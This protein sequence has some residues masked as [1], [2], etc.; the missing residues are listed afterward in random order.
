MTFL[1]YKELK[2][3]KYN[4]VTSCKFFDLDFPVELLKVKDWY[5]D[6]LTP[7][8][9]SIVDTQNMGSN[10]EERESIRRWF[11]TFFGSFWKV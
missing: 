7:F 4:T 8:F 3:P 2:D 11:Y 5:N 1:T 6:I 10:A 9:Q